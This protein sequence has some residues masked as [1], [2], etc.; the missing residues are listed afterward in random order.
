[1]ITYEQPL[2]E[3][4]R[5]FLRFELLVKRL[6]YHAGKSDQTDMLAALT[7]LLD[8][9]NLSSRLELKSD[10]IKDIERMA[11]M[12]RRSSTEANQDDAQLQRLNEQA[13]RM[14]QLRGSLGQHLRNHVF[15]SGLRQRTSLPGGLNGSDIPLL[16]YWLEQDEQTRRHDLLSWSEPFIT[17]ANAVA[18]VLNLIRQHC[19]GSEHLAQDGFFQ[20]SLGMNK[21][22]Q[23]L[24]IELPEALDVYPE[25]SAGKQRFSLRFVEADMLSAE[26]GKQRN[27][28]ISFCLKLCSF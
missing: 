4:I 20:M 10:V 3:K 5:L 21:T 1:M 15:F 22:Y 7:I 11:Q 25:I 6:T 16:N 17:T 18:C 2:N 27:E 23:L 26:R 14:Y 8:L 28:A 24:M 13:T 12:L 19:E 9:Y